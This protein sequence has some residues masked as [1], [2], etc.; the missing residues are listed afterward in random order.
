MLGGENL[1][2][3][4]STQTKL[5][6]LEEKIRIIRPAI[7]KQQEFVDRLRGELS[8][9]AAK[10]VQDR[11]RKALVK[12]L[13][14]ARGLVAA[15]NAERAIR[16]ELLNNGY[17]ALDAFTPAPRLAAPLALGDEN[18]CDSPLWHFA[19]QLRELGIET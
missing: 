17:E 4:R 12:I 8:V 1:A 9:Q 18:L 14:A 11:H 15:A 16:A 19:K 10:L 5:A 13:D 6:A 7:A 2:D 3:D